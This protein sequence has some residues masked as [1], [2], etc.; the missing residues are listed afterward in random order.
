[1]GNPEIDAL[2]DLGLVRRREV[3]YEVFLVTEAG[4]MLLNNIEA[5]ELLS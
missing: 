2:A 5:Q 3:G 4:I 1:M